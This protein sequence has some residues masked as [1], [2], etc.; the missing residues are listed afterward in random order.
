MER[1]VCIS[2]PTAYSMYRNVLLD[3][4]NFGWHLTNDYQSHHL[5]SWLVSKR[6][7]Q[8]TFLQRFSI[9]CHIVLQVTL[10]LRFHNEDIFSFDLHNM[11]KNCHTDALTI[12]CFLLSLLSHWYRPIDLSCFSLQTTNTHVNCYLS[13]YI[14]DN[15]AA[16]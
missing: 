14:K 5:T 12:L 8:Q 2:F 9:N 13:V 11:W 6:H 15:H 1:Y 3:Q 4:M 16:F 7:W 10:V